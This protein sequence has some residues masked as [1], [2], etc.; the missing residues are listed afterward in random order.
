M[1]TFDGEIREIPGVYVDNFSYKGGV[2]FLTHNHLDHLKSLLSNSFCGR[3]YCSQLTKDIIALDGRYC[4]KLRYLVVKEYNKPFEIQTFCT[5]V[6]VTMLESYHCPGSC[7]FLFECANGISCLAAGDIRAEKWWV[8]S[9]IKNRYLF[10]Y[11]AGLKKLDQIYLDTTFSYRGEP[12]ISILPN[13][14]G[15]MALFEFL[16]LYPVDREIEFSFIDTVSGSEEI[17]LQV[18]D[19]FNGTLD[20]DPSIIERMKLL[21]YNNGNSNSKFTGPM[22]FNIGNSYKDS[23]LMITIKHCIDFNIV[24]Y[25][26]FYLPKKLCDVD[27]SNLTLIRI[28]NSGHQIYSYD[29]KTWLL[30]LNGKE[31]LPTNLMIM[32]SRHSSYEELIEFVKLFKPKLVFP[33]VES[34]A[35]WLNGF[36]VG[37]VFG[38][39]CSSSKHLFDIEN[40]KKFGQPLRIVLDRPVSKINRWSFAQCIEEVNFVKNFI[41]QPGPFKGQMKLGQDSAARKSWFQD[42]NLQSIIAGRGEEKYKQIINYHSNNDLRLIV[43]SVQDKRNHKFDSDTETESVCSTDYDTDSLTTTNSSVI[44]SSCKFEKSFSEVQSMPDGNF[45]SPSL[46]LHK[47]SK[48]SDA[49]RLDRRSWNSFKLKSVN[50]KTR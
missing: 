36:T 26:G 41:T 10:P 34:K 42:V 2:F 5:S 50:S 14:E 22:V 46:N 18:L 28:L 6:T 9:L 27:A 20:A 43:S 38:R 11:I 1:S 32:F 13:S 4:D 44:A 15:I 16:K 48:I 29:G 24:D 37:R 17:W 47:I 45:L 33:C 49:I 40:F 31:L 39:V 8:S 30:P 25:A 3:V 7:M 19:H 35:S 12:Y 21:N 23:P